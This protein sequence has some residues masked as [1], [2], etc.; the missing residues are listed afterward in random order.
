M[1][2][3]TSNILALACDEGI[4]QRRDEILAAFLKNLPGQ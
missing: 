3:T 2:S 1:E 4:L